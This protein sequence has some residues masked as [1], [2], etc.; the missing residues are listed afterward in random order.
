MSV[1]GRIGLILIIA[2]ALVD[3]VIL[4]SGARHAASAIETHAMAAETITDSQAV[5]SEPAKHEPL[6]ATALKQINLLVNKP[7]ERPTGI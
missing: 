3:A 5:P 7:R 4:L 6:L 1:P 2:L